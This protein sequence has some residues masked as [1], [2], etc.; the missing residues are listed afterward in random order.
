MPTSRI[1]TP[2][3]NPVPMPLTMASLAAKRIAR[4]RTGRAVRSSCA[5]SAGNNKWRTNRSPCFLN[6]R[7][8]RSTCKTS[9]PMPKIMSLRT[10]S[11]AVHQ[12]LHIAYRLGQPI[13]DGA[14]HDRVP[15]VELDD[16][17]DRRDRLDI[18]IVQ[19]MTGVDRQ[20]QGGCEL[21]R[22]SQPFKFAGARAPGRF[23]VR[24]GMQLDDR[25]ADAAAR[26]DLRLV[27]IDE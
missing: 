12:F 3:A 16:F 11:R 6:T 23:R 20:P 4:K 13:D 15:D 27:G 17:R 8:I 26:F 21:R 14:C 9:M 24:A 19:P 18:V 5:R 25:S 22:V 7:S 1:H 10:G 2:C